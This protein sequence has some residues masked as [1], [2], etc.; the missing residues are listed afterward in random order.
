MTTQLRHVWQEECDKSKPKMDIR[1]FLEEQDE[2]ATSREV[3]RGAGG[4]NIDNV[5]SLLRELEAA[6]VVEHEVGENNTKLWQLADDDWEPP[7]YVDRTEETDAETIPEYLADQRL[8]TIPF[9]VGVVVS[10][11]YLLVAPIL[12]I[13][14]GGW[15]SVWIASVVGLLTIVAVAITEVHR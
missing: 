14:V 3:A 6:G 4:R 11:G 8:F 12:R 7:R 10:T 5:R 15:D 2:P 13:P 9:G 1:V